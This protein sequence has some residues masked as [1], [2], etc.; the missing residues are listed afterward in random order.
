MNKIY[1]IDDDMDD[2]DLFRE[3][4]EE[5]D[6]TISLQYANDGKQAVVALSQP[7]FSLPDLIFLDISMP[8]FSGL[9]CLDTF[10]K[11]DKLKK[12]PVIMYTTSSRDY[13]IRQA[14]ELGTA[15][16]L[17]KPNDFKILK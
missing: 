9:Q 5:V 6:P 7:T 16:F 13:E 2:V 3:A 10:K 8:S 12:V 11:D 14:K 1:L 17:T 15:G 4:L